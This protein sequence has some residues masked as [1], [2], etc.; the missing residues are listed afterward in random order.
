MKL[1]QA[2]VLQ[3]LRAAQS[4]LDTNGARLGE[5]GK[6]VRKRLDD[7][8]E[9]L[10][11]HA[12]TQSGSFLQAKGSTKE[13]RALRE[14]LRRDHMAPIA[15]IARLELAG[16]PNIEALRMPRGRVIGERL[17]A[18]ARGMGNMAAQFA[19]TFVAAGLPADFVEQLEAA[20]V[21]MLGTLTQRT[22]SRRFR[23]GATAGLRT[24]LSEGRKIVDALDAFVQRALK[25]DLVLLAE[26]N[27]IRRVQGVPISRADAPAGNPPFD[28]TGGAE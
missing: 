5:L 3:S 17:A 8:V 13:Q 25:D 9:K 7:A 2:S 24:K 22:D 27:S 1:N 11:S 10:T 20:T 12:A 15:R 14:A 23:V 16:V 19:P 26:W 6:G 28:S 18:A 21:A 4:F